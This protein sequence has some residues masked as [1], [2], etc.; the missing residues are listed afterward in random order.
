MVADDIAVVIRVAIES[1]I[2]ADISLV[3]MMDEHPRIAALG[4]HEPAVFIAMRFLAKQKSVTGAVGDLY[5]FHGAIEIGDAV[6][7]PLSAR[8]TTGAVGAAV[9]AVVFLIFGDT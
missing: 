4:V 6:L 1:R 5:H 3:G 9:D 2:V 7:V 8:W